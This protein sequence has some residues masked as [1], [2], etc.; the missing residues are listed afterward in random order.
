MIKKEDSSN[1]KK[2]N[3]GIDKEME[4]KKKKENL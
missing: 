3:F 1:F 2:E 4:T